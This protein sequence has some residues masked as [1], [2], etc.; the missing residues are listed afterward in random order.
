MEIT[1]KS[2]FTV[3][4]KA[5]AMMIVLALVCGTAV[6]VYSSFFAKKIYTSSVT[7]FLFSP[8]ASEGES[9]TSKE[10]MSNYNNIL[11]VGSRMLPNIMEVVLNE[12]TMTLLLRYVDEMAETDPS[13]RLDGEYTG[14]KLAGMMSYKVSDA[15]DYSLVFRIS[16][17][18]YSAHDAQILL[19]AL[20]AQ[21]AEV[22]REMDIN[23]V[24]SFRRV[25]APNAGRLTSPRVTTN[26]A[27]G[28]LLGAVVTYLAYFVAHLMYSRVYTEEDL[29]ERFD[30]PVL[31][32]IP[33]IEGG[34][35]A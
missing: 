32:Q 17:K 30:F 6:F 16:C 11:V 31:A 22:L 26:T 10:N 18:A 13:Y 3:L 23:D 21:Q 29:K 15:A 33:R 4:K 9:S 2:L 24:F 14:A 34:D 27:I 28:A 19:E 12:E 8:T 5:L 25:T 7:Y 1:V 20:D 35:K